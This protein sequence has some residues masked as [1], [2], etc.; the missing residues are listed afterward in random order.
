LYKK[1]NSNKLAPAERKGADLARHMTRIATPF[2]GNEEGIKGNN[3][4]GRMNST[5]KLYNI[6]IDIRFLASGLDMQL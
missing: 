1:D 4:S 3:I 6:S 2:R 5:M